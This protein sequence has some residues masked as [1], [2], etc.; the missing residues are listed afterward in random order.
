MAPVPVTGRAGARAGVAAAGRGVTAARG[1][2]GCF[3]AAAA[4]RAAAGCGRTGSNPAGSGAG[5]GRGVCAFAAARARL[6][7]LPVVG[8]GIALVAPGA[9]GAGM[10]LPGAG[11]NQPDGA[12]GSASGR[13][14][15]LLRGFG[16][17]R[18]SGFHSVG[19]E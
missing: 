10:R 9:G 2:A 6:A 16:R 18:G 11:F 7:V 17:A 8:G 14:V 5:L 1:A 15:V 19:R 3:I 13:G 4:G 12:T